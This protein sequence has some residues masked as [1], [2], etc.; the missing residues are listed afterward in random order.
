MHFLGR[1]IRLSLLCVNLLIILL[2]FEHL[3]L[4]PYLS[5]IGER[6]FLL[7]ANIWLGL[8]LIVTDVHSI[9]W[10]LSPS[11]QRSQC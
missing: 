7:A 6:K 11:R 4:F 3:I 1:H 8:C 5:R 10:Q 2:R 9:L